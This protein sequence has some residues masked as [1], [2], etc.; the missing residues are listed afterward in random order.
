MENILN[1]KLNKGLGYSIEERQRLGIH[2]LLPP[3]VQTQKDQEK[4]VLENLKRI[5][6]DIDKYIYLMHLLD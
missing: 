5:K 6:E 4:L 3:C 2:G 1:S